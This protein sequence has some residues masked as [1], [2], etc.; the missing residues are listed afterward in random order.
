MQLRKRGLFP[1]SPAAPIAA[2]TLLEFQKNPG[3]NGLLLL[4]SPFTWKKREKKEEEGKK[5]KELNSATSSLP[6]LL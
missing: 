4:A 5:K 3:S 6:L 1:S 2:E